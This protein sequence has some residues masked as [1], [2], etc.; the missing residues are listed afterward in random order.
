MDNEFILLIGAALLPAIV[1]CI[2]IFIKD[3]AEKEPAG[4]LI[5]LLVFGVLISIP[6]IFFESVLQ[7]LFDIA[8]ASQLV[9]TEEGLVC[10]GPL[11]Y[12]YYACEGFI[13]AAFVEESLK[14]T[15]LYFT[16]RRNKNFNSLFDGLIYSVF[17]SLGFAGFENILYVLQYGWG[18]AIM[19]AVTS[20][21]GHMFFAVFMGYF[22]SMWHMNEK[23]GAVERQLKGMGVIPSESIEFSG[24]KHLALSL[25]IP[26]LIH[27]LYD[28]CLMVGDYILIIAFYG[29]LI[30]L[31]IY[32][33]G[34]IRKMSATDML[35]NRYVASM[36]VWKYPGIAE[37]FRQVTAQPG[38][39]PGAPTYG[40]PGVNPGAPT[41]GQPGY[42][43]GAA[44]YGQ[45]GVN[46]GAP[47]YGQHGY[48]PGAQTYGQPD[49]TP[50]AQTYG[51]PGYNRETTAYGQSDV[52]R[53]AI[54][55]DQPD[56]NTETTANSN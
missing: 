17:V 48:N 13:V 45:P 8:F 15:A 55:D 50:G 2:Y 43:P 31:Y 29:L 53:E 12:L 14:W 23:A 5:R 54:P 25:L 28:Y 7:S 9:E 30:G 1:L 33:F 46:P 52:V 11:R 19:Q 41:Y 3:R 27:G 47:T 42:N 4:L 51:Q 38:Y 34:V 35:D 10:Q 56:F 37:K 26:I 36:L 44:T 24:K 16:T 18:T 20:I 32:C 40:Q 21:P 22:Y 49:F 39:N 6:A